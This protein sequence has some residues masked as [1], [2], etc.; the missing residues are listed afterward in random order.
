VVSKI[1]ETDPV[2]EA[3]SLHAARLEL[4]LGRAAA[5]IEHLRGVVARNESSAQAHELLAV[6][7]RLTGDAQSAA[8]HAAI[9][10]RLAP[11]ESKP[12]N[13]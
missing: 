5:A 4:G 12:A 6:A 8:R 9:H 13:R 10:E 2:H 7:Y 11:I 1:L 3:A